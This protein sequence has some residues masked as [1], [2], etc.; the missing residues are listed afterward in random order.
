MI[1]L[2]STDCVVANNDD[3]MGRM[4]AS[5]QQQKTTMAKDCHL[6]RDDE[7]VPVTDHFLFRLPP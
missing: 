5:I 7:G 1:L 2:K 4:N 3:D 6:R